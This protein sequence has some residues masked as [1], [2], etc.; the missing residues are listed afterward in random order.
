M[1]YIESERLIL[2]QF[3]EADLTDLVKI[4]GQ[5]HILAWCSDWNDCA[6]WVHDWFKGRSQR[7]FG[8]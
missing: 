8:Q 1:S 5:K 6:N 3:T 7:F 2:R 4:A